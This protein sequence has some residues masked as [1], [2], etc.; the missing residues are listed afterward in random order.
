MKKSL[1][2]ISSFVFILI[3]NPFCNAQQIPYLKD[4]NNI[5]CLNSGK[6]DQLL[7]NNAF[8]EDCL[9]DFIPQ[10]KYTLISNADT[11]RQKSFQ[12][13]DLVNLFLKENDKGGQ[14]KLLKIRKIP[15]EEFSSS[16]LPPFFSI[17]NSLYLHL[18]INK[19]GTVEEVYIRDNQ[20][21]ESRLKKSQELYYELKKSTWQPGLYNTK[22]VNASLNYLVIF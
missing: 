20:I 14:K 1:I 16:A 11:L 5:F 18:K 8:F 7:K 9:L 22:P 3:Y 10:L 15:A 2:F 21:S 4:N 6:E 12:F 17:K 13:K 19:D